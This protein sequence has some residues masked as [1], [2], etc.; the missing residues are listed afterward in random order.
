MPSE[1]AE[2]PASLRQTI[3]GLD[4]RGPKVFGASSDA[5]VRV[6]FF[7]NGSQ[8]NYAAN[9]LLRMRTAHAG[10]N[11]NHTRAFIALD[12]SVIAPYTPS[13]LV[14]TGEPL[15]HGAAIYG[16]GFRRLASHSRSRYEIP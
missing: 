1:A 6:D 7:A 8:S 12:R 10:L 15:W 2:A 13:S 11:W 4:A 9:G 16:H 5:D 3:L 14:A